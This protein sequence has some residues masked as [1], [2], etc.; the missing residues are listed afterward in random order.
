MAAKI[1][2]VCISNDESVRSQ[3]SLLRGDHGTGLG[4]H[5]GV[6]PDANSTTWKAEPATSSTARSVI[7]RETTR[8]PAFH[9]PLPVR[10][11]DVRGS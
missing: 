1:P 4:H 6:T 7:T 11:A 8:R 9:T 2:V 3:R 5:L 10:A